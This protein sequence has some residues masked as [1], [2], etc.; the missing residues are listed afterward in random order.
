MP[1]SIIYFDKDSIIISSIIRALSEKYYKSINLIKKEKN[2]DNFRDKKHEEI[3]DSSSNNE[4]YVYV[5][6]PV[7]N[8]YYKIDEY[9]GYIITTVPIEYDG[10]YENIF[11]IKY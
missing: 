6:S 9:F 2:V 8:Y 3:K 4:V 1:E 11:E 7:F 10:I 5:S